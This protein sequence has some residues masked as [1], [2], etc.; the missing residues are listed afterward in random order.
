MRFGNLWQDFPESFKNSDRGPPVLVNPPCWGYSYRMT[1]SAEALFSEALDLSA[2]ERLELA[3]EII[4][5]VDGPPDPDWD[6]AWLAELDRRMDE[7]ARGAEPLPEWA[8]VRAGILK[9]LA[10]R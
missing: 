10:R 6:R 2:K 8:E 1:R 7:S 4:A 3:S 9:R 5:S